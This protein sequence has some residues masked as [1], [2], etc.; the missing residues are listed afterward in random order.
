MESAQFHQHLSRRLPEL[1]AGELAELTAAFTLCKV[2]KRS[3]RLTHLRRT[4]RFPG[5]RH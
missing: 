1:T 4:G 5:L 3:G 2:K